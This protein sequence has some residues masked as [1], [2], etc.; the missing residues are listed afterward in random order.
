MCPGVVGRE[1]KERR[2]GKRRADQGEDLRLWGILPTPLQGDAS[3][4]ICISPWSSVAE[5]GSNI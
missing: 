2:W 3:E 1:G 5:T 4:G